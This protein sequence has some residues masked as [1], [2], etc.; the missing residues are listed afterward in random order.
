[1]DKVTKN[2]NAPF[3]VPRFLLGLYRVAPRTVAIFM[4][5][6]MLFAVLTTTIAP[7][8]VS[9]LLVSITDGSANLHS[10]ITLLSLYAASLFLGDVVFIRLSIF[11]AYKSENKMQ[12]AVAKQVF[13]HLE[14]RS[15]GYHAN[16]MT[17]GTVSNATKLNGSIEKFW[18]TMMFTVVPIATTL[19]SVSIALSLILWQYAVILLTIS[20]AIIFVI[21]KA[22]NA[23]TPISRQ[24]AEKSSALTAHIAD[25]IGNISAVKAFA[26]EKD[27]AKAYAGKIDE[28]LSANRRE[29]KKVVVVSGAFG[30]LMTFLNVAAFI[31]AI[32]ATELKLANVGTIYLVIV[33]TLSVVSQLWSVTSATRSYI[34]IIGDASPMITTLAEPIEIIDIKNPRAASIER[35]HI[36]IDHITFT[37]DGNSAPLFNDFSLDIPAGQHVGLVGHSGSGKTSLSRLLMRFNDV[38]SGAITIDQNDIAKIKQADL[39]RAISYVPQEPLLFHRSLRDN[40]AYGA[41]SASDSEIFEVARLAHVAEFAESLPG[42]YDTI[43]GER[44]VKLSGGQRQRIAIARAILKSAPILLLDEATSA[45]DSESER[46]IQQSL[47][48]LMQNRTSIVIAH[49]LSTI[50]K[51]D[52][53]VV[54]DDGKVV[55]DGTHEQL[56]RLHGVYARLWRHQSGGFID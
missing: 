47:A 50:A 31:A 9:R 24:V 13:A 52:R 37:H 29:M 54:L 16:N 51:L 28:W 23:V 7:L 33:Y 14:A 46:L 2:S 45:L 21:I 32:Y 43:V 49:R 34:R 5:T 35:G 36:V 1:M 3:A 22:Q 38:E 8:F 15:L 4:L 40:I 17:G 42:G 44:G 6:Q 26:R 10:S 41:P 53:I 39:H 27:E 19:I 48:T 12:A 30:I 11:L 55:E 25:V 18:D 56:L 20:L